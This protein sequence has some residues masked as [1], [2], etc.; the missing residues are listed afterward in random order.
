LAVAQH[1]PRGRHQAGDRHL[2]FHED[3]DNLPMIPLRPSMPLTSPFCSWLTAPLM[4]SR[5]CIRGAEIA[6]HKVGLA[7]ASSVARR[8]WR[9]MNSA[10]APALRNV[11]I[12]P[13]APLRNA[14]LR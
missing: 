5:S 2:K 13:L 3:R 1:L 8:T 6:L 11:R 12:R 7:L 4:L 10:A 14:P 9:L